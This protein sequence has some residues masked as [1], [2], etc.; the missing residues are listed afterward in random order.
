MAASEA[1]RVRM[2][3]ILD[4]WGGLGLAV[5]GRCLARCEV[6]TEEGVCGIVCG[7]VAFCEGALSGTL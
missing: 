1:R 6:L 7:C 2:I 5:R 4:V 3:I